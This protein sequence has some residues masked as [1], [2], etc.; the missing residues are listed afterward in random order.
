MDVLAKGNSN[1]NASNGHETRHTQSS[2]RDSVKWIAD[3]VAALGLALGDEPS[4]ERLLV[5]AEDL[6]DIP[7]ERLTAA[8]RKTRR[9]YEYPKLPPVAFIRRMAGAGENA[10]GRP[11]SEEAWARMPKGERMEDDSVVWCEEE[12]IAYGACRSLLLEGDPIGARMAFKERYEKELARARSQGKPAHWTISS[13]YDVEHRLSTL[14]SAFQDK[15]IDLDYALN[16]VPSERREDFARMLP[17]DETKG[18]LTGRV[19]KL[20]DL[21]GLPGLL[22]KMKIQ[23]LAP[24]ELKPASERRLIAATE[25]TPEQR[26]KRREE[27]TAQA[28]YLKRSR[29]GPGATEK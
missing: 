19:E 1:S 24:D 27:L 7:Q 9:E 3:Q 6:C 8:F 21:P 14:A 11:G 16:F 15:R 25:L 10:D 4:A 13:G 5:Y 29:N 20:P 28:E 2:T 18:L 26:C 17:S 22:A 23:G 12:R